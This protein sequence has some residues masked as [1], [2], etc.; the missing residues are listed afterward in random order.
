[1]ANDVLVLGTGNV[2][3]LLLEYSIPAIIAMMASSLYNIVDSVFIGHGVGA[4]AI[5]GLAITFPLMNLSA[6]FGSL[7]G[8]GGATLVSIKMGQQDTENAEK[9]LGNVVSLNIIL[10]ITFMVLGLWFL[11]PILSFFGASA[12]TMPYAYDYMFVILIGNVVTHL[13]LG[14]NN[15]MRSSGYPRKAMIM[16]LITIVI[17]TALDPIF[18]FGFRWGIRGAAIATVLAQIVAL[19][20]VVGHFSKK[21]HTVYF[22]TG[23]FRLRKRIVNGIFSIGMAPFMVNACSCLVVV[24]INKALYTHGGDLAIGA[25]GI[26]NRIMMLFGMLVMGFNQGMQPI[27]GYNF[28]A[29]Q[30]DRVKSV[31]KLTIFYASCVMCVG[32]LAGE[33]FPRAL[34]IMFT[35]DENLIALSVKGMRIALSAAPVVGFQMVVSN[36]FQSIGQA[37]KAVFLSSTRQLLFLVP[38]L[39]I[40]PNFFGTT[41]VWLSMPISDVLAAILAAVLLFRDKTLKIKQS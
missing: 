17:N 33:L 12:D 5:S 8:A 32:F 15:V 18:I 6:A 13:Y 20:L 39:L 37:P 11:K 4:L 29:Q 34:S 3:K 16:T 7:I 14:L 26:I 35:T 36:F 19:A 28:G 10:G 25:Y 38:L 1:M 27:A 24:I 31:L 30:N 9:V 40:L 22:K 21:T 2:K 41:G 23:I